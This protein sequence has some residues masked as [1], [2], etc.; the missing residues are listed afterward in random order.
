MNQDQ[1]PQTDNPDPCIVCGDP[2]DEADHIPPKRM[3]AG[4]RDDDLITVPICAD[5][6]DGT[7]QDDE[8]FRMKVALLDDAFEHPEVQAGVY[9]AIKRSFQRPEAAGWTQAFLDDVGLEQV[10]GRIRVT[11]KVDMNRIYSTVE[12]Y[13]RGLHYY[14]F[15]R[16][17]PPDREVRIAC[18]HAS[19]GAPQ[20]WQQFKRL[21]PH[22]RQQ[23]ARTRGRANA[24]RYHYLVREGSGDQRISVW[25]LSFY[26]G[27]IRFLAIS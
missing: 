20:P 5:C 6:H 18:D 25:L 15:D 22:L 4:P 11:S 24:F 16:I 21:V 13:V 10:R 23:P 2:A 9:D 26:G 12:R 17:L 8:Y 14:E 19:G 27:A 3:F 1:V 7:G